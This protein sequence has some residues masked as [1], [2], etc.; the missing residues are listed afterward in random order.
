ARDRQRRGASPP[1]PR[2]A[3]RVRAHRDVGTGGRSRRHDAGRGPRARRLDRARGA[4]AG[5]E[6]MIGVLLADDRELVRA[7]F[8]VVL[9]AEGGISVVGVAATGREAVETA[10]RLRPDVVLMDIRMPGMDGLEAT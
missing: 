9:E 5:A 8:R 7:G 3:R 4:A 1:A 6:P 10:A 2:G